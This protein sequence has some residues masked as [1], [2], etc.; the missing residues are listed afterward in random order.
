VVTAGHTRCHAVTPVVNHREPLLDALALQL[1]VVRTLEPPDLLRPSRCEG[2]SVRDVLNHSMGV[3]VKFTDFAAG[4]TDQPRT[5]PGDVLGRDHRAAFEGVAQS[6]RVAWASADMSRVCRL[7]FGTFS[8]DLTAG[9]NLF[10]L[11]AHTWD[12]GATPLDGAEELWIAALDAA[13]SVIGPDRDIHQYGPE[14]V[15]R[16]Q[17]GRDRFL[18]FLGRDSGP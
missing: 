6:A 18:A 3:T 16:S 11:L 14:L 9:I 5:P 7:P 4:R 12:V 10:D 8:A 2:W 1:D 15:P 13:V 17:S